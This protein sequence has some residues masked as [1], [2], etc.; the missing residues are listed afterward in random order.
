MQMPN[1]MQTL[2]KFKLF[3]CS[4]NI[5]TFAFRFYCVY[6]V[7]VLSSDFLPK[8]NT[9]SKSTSIYKIVFFLAFIFFLFQFLILYFFIPWTDNVRFFL[10]VFCYWKHARWY[11]FRKII[12]SGLNHVR[13]AR[14]KD[15]KT[16]SA[17]IERKRHTCN[18][19]CFHL[20]IPK[21]YVAEEIENILVS[22]KQI[23]SCGRSMLSRCRSTAT[24]RPHTATTR[25]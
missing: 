3:Y 9:S 4:S 8:L 11:C 18:L 7:N 16:F 25:K 20:Y 23:M 14:P 21:Y 15:R 6:F 2:N 19:I 5:Q 24:T 1:K 17:F 13:I 22:I 12:V 10:R